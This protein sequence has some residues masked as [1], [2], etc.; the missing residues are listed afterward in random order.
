MI[1][2]FLKRY[3]FIS[4]ISFIPS[5]CFADWVQISTSAG[6]VRNFMDPKTIKELPSGNIQVWTKSEYDRPNERGW[7]SATAMVESNCTEKKSRLVVFAGFEKSFLKGKRVDVDLEQSGWFFIEPN[8]N[9]QILL[10]LTCN[11]KSPR[12]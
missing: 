3:F 5:F 10:D 4:V 9:G 12:R 7:R 2:S 11:P 6:Y 1:E 8:S